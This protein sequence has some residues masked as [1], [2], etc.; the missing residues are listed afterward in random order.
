MKKI[1]WSVVGCMVMASC[2]SNEIANSAD[3]KQSGIHQKYTISYTEEN[4]QTHV[5]ATYR[6]GGENGTTLVLSPPSTVTL[7]GENMTRYESEF[8]GAYYNSAYSRPLANGAQCT[9]VFTDTDG[10]TYTNSIMFNPV[11]LGPIPQ[12]VKK[13]LPLEIP[14]VTHPLKYGDKITIH[15]SDSAHS[16]SFILENVNLEKRLIIPATL[17]NKLSGKVSLEITRSNSSLL[18]EKTDEGGT[19][20]FEYILKKHEFEIR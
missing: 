8:V 19:I 12:E 2:A 13:G 4:N 6:F 3:V 15:L 9:F 17:L 16:D 1:L 18:T 10:K 20:S 5:K 11:L 14:M 7:N